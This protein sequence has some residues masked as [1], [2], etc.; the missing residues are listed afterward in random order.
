M[1][2]NSFN[3][4]RGV[5]ILFI[6]A[7][8]TLYMSGWTIDTV[9]EK[10]LADLVL[11][12]TT[13]FVFISGFLF[14]HV[15]FKRYN[16]RKFMG[17]KFRNVLL[18]YLV[19]SLP[20]VLYFVLFT[21]WG[22]YGHHIFGEKTGL[23]SS[24]LLPVLRYLW[25]G[26][27]MEAYWYIPFIM[28]VFVFSPLMMAYARLRPAPRVAIFFVLL[29][30]SLFL[31]RPI[32]NISVLHSTIYF[33]PVF[34]FGITVSID[35]EW[36]YR[37]FDRREPLLLAAVFLFA[38]LQARYYPVFGNLHKPALQAA[39][40]DVLLLQKLFLALFFMILLHRYEERESWVLDRLASTSFAI[41]FLHPWV[42]WGAQLVFNQRLAVIESM[43][44]P[45]LWLVMTPLVV[46]LSMALAE[47]IRYLFRDHSR[48]VIG[49]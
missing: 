38:F 42:L 40:P 21:G 8:H 48:S 6:V 20:L 17:T 9:F 12:G 49:Y 33:L 18:P 19:L 45:V 23:L 10:F 14:H 43:R 27:V 31:Q 46:V 29:L 26:R 11:G 35:K 32:D 3:Y 30:V 4:F 1:W 7:G 28:V 2:L 39:L 15:Y 16:Y 47:G 41:Y 13:L 36:F 37:V 5:A 25:T 34:L 22:P 24:Y 44:G